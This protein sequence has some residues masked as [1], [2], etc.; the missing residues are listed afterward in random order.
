VRLKI[1]RRLKLW[2]TL[3]L[4]EEQDPFVGGMMHAAVNTD[5]TRSRHKL[6][7]CVWPDPSTSVKRP[8]SILGVVVHITHT[9]YIDRQFLVT[10]IHRP[11]LRSPVPQWLVRCLALIPRPGKI[12]HRLHLCAHFGDH[13]AD[14]HSSF[15]ALVP[16]R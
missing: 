7:R 15:D 2:E 3:A 4:E 9:R 13:I 6:R 14:L 10:Q 1:I 8:S 16:C 5:A 11:A 12:N